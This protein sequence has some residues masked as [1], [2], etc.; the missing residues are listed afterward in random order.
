MFESA[1][2]ILT[3]GKRKLATMGLTVVAVMASA[4]SAF[5][6]TADISTE[7][8]SVSTELLGTFSSAAN[9][10]KLII[11]GVIGIVSV[12]IL[13]KIAFRQGISFFKSG[14]RQ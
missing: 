8:A 4:V 11:L 14:V 5:A 1:K 10:I 12:V 7:M 2:K 13:I 9:S 3:K 6:E